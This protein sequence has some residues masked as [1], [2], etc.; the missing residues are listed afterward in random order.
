MADILVKEINDP[1][2]K[3]VFISDV[4]VSEDLKKARIFVSIMPF[5]DHSER[6]DWSHMV[7]LDELIA[8]L[9]RAKGVIKRA[10]SRRMHLRYIPEL[11]FLNDNIMKMPIGQ[12]GERLLNN[13][14]E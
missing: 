9:I 13:D 3:K 7:E 14:M 2:L 12:E 6:D 5:P 4:I 11:L 8:R 1:L 10:L